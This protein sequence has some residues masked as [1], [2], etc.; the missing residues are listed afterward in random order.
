MTR[1]TDTTPTPATLRDKQ[2]SRWGDPRKIMLAA[3]RQIER[4]ERTQQMVAA[5]D[6]ARAAL[7]FHP[8]SSTPTPARP[9]GYDAELEAI[10]AGLDLEADLGR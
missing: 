6:E 3:L 9:A 1:V 10:L 5:G 2:R 7:T 8:H 4:Q